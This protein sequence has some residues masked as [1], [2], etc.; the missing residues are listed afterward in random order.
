MN[1][2]AKSQSVELMSLWFR[3]GIKIEL[4]TLY[5]QVTLSSLYYCSYVFVKFTVAMK[6]L[7][8]EGHV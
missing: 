8:F 5:F 2:E 6:I 3:G 1:M 4:E 7:S